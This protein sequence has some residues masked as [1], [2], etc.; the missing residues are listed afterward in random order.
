MDKGVIPSSAR[1][2]LD[3]C[4]QNEPTSNSTALERGEG[5]GHAGGRARDRCGRSPQVLTH[6]AGGVRH[7]PS[8]TWFSAIEHCSG[9]EQSQINISSH[10]NGINAGKNDPSLAQDHSWNHRYL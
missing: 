7:I 6:V 1:P 2:C 8:S 3:P 9:C 10:F 5:Q 4:L